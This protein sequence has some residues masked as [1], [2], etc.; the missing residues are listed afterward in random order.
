MLLGSCGVLSTSGTMV[1]TLDCIFPAIATL[2]YWGLMLAGIVGAIFIIIA[3]IRFILS[4]G[5]PKNVDQAKKIF[6]YAVLGLA[7]VFL[8]FF[9]VNFIAT[10]TGVSCI[11]TNYLSFTTCK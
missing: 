5:N 11:S 7:I 10:T 1:A 4:G 3:G 9:I 6:V 2:I 8:A